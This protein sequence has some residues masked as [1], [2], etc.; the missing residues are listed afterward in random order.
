[1]PDRPLSARGCASASH[2]LKSPTTLTE[3]ALGA[4]TAKT[5]PPT[6]ETSAGWAPSVPYNPK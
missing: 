5:V 1:M 3:R 6:P 2:P 4:H